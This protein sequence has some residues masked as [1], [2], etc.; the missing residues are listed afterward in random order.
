MD[1]LLEAVLSIGQELD[2]S[3]ALQRI[4]EA[5]A[6]LVDA[7]Y[8]ALGVVGEDARLSQFLTVGVSDEQH[9]AI[10]PLP[11]GQGILGELIRH[12]GLLRLHDLSYH[13]SSRGFPSHH[14]SMHTF[15]GTSI[16]VRDEVFGNLY[17]TQKR[18]GQ[19]FD[20]EDETVLSTLAVAAGIAIENA[21]L[22]ER[23]RHR[24]SW[25]E[26]NA[27]IV[28]SLLSGTSETSV[29]RQ[30]LDFANRILASDLG[31]VALPVAGT[32]DLHIALAVG[33]DASDHRGLVV[34]RKGSFVGAAVTAQGPITTKDVQHD[35]RI[36]VGPP[37]WT[38]LG[39]AV[40]VPMGIGG[41]ARGVIMLAR[42]ALSAP[43]TATDTEPL[44]AFA[45]QAS[46][47]MELA[48]RRRN[49]EQVA[50]LEDRDRI[51]R[52]LHDLAI[53]R[54]FATGMTLQSAVRF[55]Q[56]PEASERLLR[57]VDDLDETIKIIR[58]TIFGLRS[59]ESG[60]AAE[61]LR[62]RT[63]GT[64]DQA[65]SALGFTP[66]LRMEGLIDT[67]VPASVADHVVAVLG[68]AL[69]NVARHA[70]ASST[71]VSLVVR[72]GT[73][74]LTVADNGCGIAAGTPRRGL[75]NLAER[76][77]ELGGRLTVTPLDSGTR[78]VWQVSA[79]PR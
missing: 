76:A 50:L 17:L 23:A 40:A 46:L 30:M 60:R 18:D 67:D 2:L 52:D 70:Q 33:I 14:P 62:S 7:E 73:L 63:A 59:H 42:K 34:P 29:L 6:T 54:L 3:R 58:S 72:S 16:R 4:V 20:D 5:A 43:Y 26:A 57:A 32:D 78:L 79:V 19:D 27:Q 65:V 39:P 24:Q 75:R 45:G 12:P 15:L 64:V 10:G 22:Y 61:G 21:R 38:G 11:S 55:V 48:E 44:M 77:E 51:A 53:Q 31:A 49:D 8:G 68:E 37:R 36:T 25:L 66:A 74:T 13:P 41:A 47:A 71:D 1:S 28:S 69:A 35:P 56:H 9:R